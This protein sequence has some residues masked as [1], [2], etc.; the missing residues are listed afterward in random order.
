MK[1]S[2]PTFRQRQLGRELRRL[3][4]QA[5]LSQEKAATLLRYTDST[6][7]RIENGQLPPY[8]GLRA[9]LDLYGVTVD[10]WDWYLDLYDRAREKGWWHAYGLLDAGYVGME[11][12]ACRVREF[13]LGLVPGLLQTDDY[14]RAVF[15]VSPTQWSTD[16][17]EVGVAIRRKRQERLTADPPLEFHAILDETVLHRRLPDVEATRAQLRHIARAAGLP[18]VTV[19]VLPSDVGLH[20]GLVS[21]FT[22]V[23]FPD[24]QDRDVVYLEHVAGALHVEKESEVAKCRLDF[25]R[26]A[27]LALSPEESVALIERVADQR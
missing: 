6:I 13:Q 10:Q 22:I 20:Y 7:S 5:G 17:V 1:R 4:E 11:D 19:Q 24:R 26:L 8:H 14:I 25:D 9:M 15:A 12:E 3:R 2:R 21:S 23:S 18:N 27:A 16:A